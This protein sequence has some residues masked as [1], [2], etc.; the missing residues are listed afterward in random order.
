M[1]IRK[2]SE[3][4]EFV[5][6]LLARNI[7]ICSSC[8]HVRY[9]DFTVILTG[10]SCDDGIV[11]RIEN[12]KILTG[13]IEVTGVKGHVCRMEGIEDFRCRFF[14]D[15]PCWDGGHV[16]RFLPVAKTRTVTKTSNL[17]NIS[18]ESGRIPCDE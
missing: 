6:S 13:A 18:V 11:E 1:T 9:C 10:T 15:D 12:S 14:R 4:V 2:T 5:R 16:T 17:R 8:E 3:N 7:F